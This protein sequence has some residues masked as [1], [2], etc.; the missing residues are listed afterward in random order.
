MRR[1]EYIT[2]KTPFES[3]TAS[4]LME[5]DVITCTPDD[6]CRHAASQMTKHGIGSL[7]VVDKEGWLVGIISEFDLLQ[8][9]RKGGDPKQFRVEE[10]MSR[11]V[12]FVSEST[13]AD[14]IIKLLQTE[15]LIRVP[16]L[17]EGKLVGIV[18]RRDLLLGYI[19]ATAK[20]WP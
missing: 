8:Q 2:E 19:K 20:Y 5:S 13:K 15:H 14:E 16:V 4:I 3:L 10:A 17:K 6:T 12:R 7:P 11:E 18:A 1:T 9:L